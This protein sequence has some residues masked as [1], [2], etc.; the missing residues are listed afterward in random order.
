MRRAPAGPVRA[1]CVRVCCT[2]AVQEHDLRATTLQCNAERGLSSHFT[3]PSSHP[4]LCKPH[5][6]SAQATLQQLLSHSKLVRREA[7]THTHTRTPSFTGKSFYAE[8]LLHGGAFTQ[9]SFYTEKLVHAASF[10]TEK[11]L[12][13]E[14]LTQTHFTT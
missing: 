2:V 4:A 11:L 13:T 10:C 14:A 5:F 1:R 8:K 3:V 7:F 9:R 6:I 12:H